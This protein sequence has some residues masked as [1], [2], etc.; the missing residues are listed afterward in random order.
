MKKLLVVVAVLA[1][2]IGGAAVALPRLIS[3]EKIQQEVKIKFNEATG[4]E[5]AFGNIRFRFW[6]NIG[7][8]LED[9]AISN[10]PWAKEKNMVTLGTLDVR[11]ALRPLLNKQVE[12]KTFV[13]TKP[14]INL[15][16]SADG[17]VSWEFGAQKAA[18]DNASGGD[19]AGA[20]KDI[21]LKLGEFQFK[22][23][24]LT[25]RDGKTGKTEQVSDID[26]AVMFPDL[27]S[28]MQADGAVTYRDKRVTVVASVEKPMELLAGKPSK[29]SVSLKSDD[30]AAKASGM[31]A[32]SGVFFRGDVD[33][34]ISSLPG[35]LAWVGDGKAKE[36]PF[37]KIA[38][39]SVADV[40]STKLVL[41]QASLSLDDI[42][43]GGEASVAY[44]G[45]KPDINARLVMDRID[46]DRFVGGKDGAAAQAQAPASSGPAGWD[47]TPIDFSGLK[48]VN[49]DL[50]LQTKGFS[51]KGA[52]VGPSNLVVV[53]KDGNLSFKSSE[54]TLFDGKF[55]SDL[56]VNASS[57][58]PS[59]SFNFKMDGVQ[60]KPVLT[61]FADFKKLSGAADANVSVTSRGNSQ[62]AIIEGLNGKGAVTFRDGSLEGIDLVN[63]A[64]KIQAKLSDMNVGEGKTDFV[65]LGGTFTVTNGVASNKDL[66]MKGPLVQ[67]TGAGDIDLPKKYVQYRVIPKLTASSAVEGASGI[68][69]PVDIKGPFHAIKVKPDYKAVIQNAL[70][71]PEEI[72]KTLKQAEDTIEPLKDDIKN[73][74]K[75][76]AKAIGGVLG[77]LGVAPPPA[78]QP[79]PAPEAA[80]APDAAPAPE[81]APVP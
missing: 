72:K 80:P 20:M 16:T 33:A 81:A 1:I 78:Q 7:L 71:N 60:A 18:N 29:S 65:E 37:T 13:L 24:L 55:T 56:G 61:T 66:A 63:I 49:A 50:I 23:G 47:A 48:A 58:V 2:L 52:E 42:T 74:K 44:G 14:V 46:L 28:A 57:S 17:K 39:K 79:A 25:Y 8:Q 6:P 54:A 51:L 68:S 64:K 62:K 40:S 75:D 21:T 3:M 11:L 43:A 34:G 32:T 36:L 12:V 41:Q 10:A 9:V 15:E 69:I 67:A 70:D 76:P 53:L 22:D 19:A 31:L 26:L 35:L 59:L 77:I 27:E 4:R 30:I 73:F 45:A 38:F 5:I